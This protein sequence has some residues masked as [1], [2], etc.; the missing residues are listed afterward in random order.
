MM[1]FILLYMSIYSHLLHILDQKSYHLECIQSLTEQV[2]KIARTYPIFTHFFL[3]RKL[4]CLFL[5]SEKRTPRTYPCFNIPKHLSGN[6]NNSLV[7]STGGNQPL[8]QFP[9]GHRLRRHVGQ[10]GGACEVRLGE[11]S[12]VLMFFSL[13][14]AD[15]VLF[16]CVVDVLFLI[17][18]Y[19]GFFCVVIRM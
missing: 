14:S 3:N 13:P 1:K 2:L 8:D 7:D 4:Y 5:L 19:F 6:L 10:P 12:S 18:M 16:L 17:T 15:I 9:A 11:F